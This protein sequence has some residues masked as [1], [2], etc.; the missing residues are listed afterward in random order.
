MQ[1]FPVIFILLIIKVMPEFNAEQIMPMLK[2]TLITKYLEKG[3]YPK[4]SKTV[5]QEKKK[6]KS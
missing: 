1:I 5:S 3:L 6:K 4:S 2:L